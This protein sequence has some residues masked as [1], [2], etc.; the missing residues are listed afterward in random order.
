MGNN[1]LINFLAQKGI[2]CD[3]SI[4]IEELGKRVIDYFDSKCEYKFFSDYCDA[5]SI[6]FGL[7]EIIEFD[8]LKG[9]DDK[10]DYEK[11]FLVNVTTGLKYAGESGEKGYA[12]EG[13]ATICKYA[14]CLSD[15][16]IEEILKFSDQFM[17]GIFG[18][19]LR[20]K[21]IK[22]IIDNSI[23]TVEQKNDMKFRFFDSYI[24]CTL[25]MRKLSA[26]IQNEYGHY[27]YIDIDELNPTERQ[28]ATFYRALEYNSERLYVK[29]DR[30]GLST[31]YLSLTPNFEPDSMKDYILDVQFVLERNGKIKVKLIDSDKVHEK[32]TVELYFKSQVWENNLYDDYFDI[33]SF[34]SVEL[35]GIYR[36]EFELIY[37][38][39]EGIY[40]CL[41]REICFV[42]YIDVVHDDKKIVIN[43]NQSVK[44]PSNFYGR[45]I[46]NICAVIGKNGSGKSSIFGM[47]ANNPIFSGRKK[48]DY[49]AEW[50]DYLIIYKLGKNYY[51]SKSIEKH[52]HV[53]IEDMKL[54]ENNDIVNV[55]ICL[56]SNTFDAH[57][58]KELHDDIVDHDNKDVGKL[59]GVIDFTT[60]NM[61]KSG[62][63]VYKQ[64]EEQRINNL[65]EFLCGKNE[66]MEFGLKEYKNLNGLSSGEYARWSLFARIFSIFHCGIKD[67]I[68]PEVQQKENYFVLFDEAELYMHPE[69]QRKLIYDIISFIEYI[70]KDQRFFSNMTIVFSSNSPF[71]MS[72]LPSDNI[73]LFEQEQRI[74]TFGQNIYDILR[75]DFFMPDE[76]MGAFA[77]EKISNAFKE[78]DKMNDEEREISTYVADVLGDELLVT[79]LR[80][81]LNV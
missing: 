65:K 5:V 31:L 62:F 6:L 64:M 9:L 47:L 36:E 1:E 10:N 52:I 34:L 71:L 13:I 79:L 4:S 26:Y 42:N 32:K 46:N 44:R 67:T 37:F 75:G 51:Y 21:V 45:Y 54:Y 15:Q 25:F 74:K 49:V 43:E 23:L 22:A 77:Y 53:C 69:W 29:V 66:I 7:A 14:G 19:R 41:K 73:I 76:A 48:V 8:D 72:D 80:R 70:N 78:V 17:D 50:G 63:K 55:N 2:D 40:G 68:L 28:R 30:I 60:T 39:A 56:L 3:G 57:A 81:H 58:V 33:S 12:Y 18:N 24:L 61:L 59:S 35:S 20:T 38:Y 11:K 16:Y 27:R